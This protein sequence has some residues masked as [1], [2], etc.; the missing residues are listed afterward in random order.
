MAL[1]F[2][3]RCEATTLTADDYSA[4]DMGASTT[5]TPALNA[6]AKREGTNGLYT[7][8]ATS[9]YYFNPTDLMASGV[10]TVGAAAF[11]IYLVT[12]LP[13]NFQTIGLYAWNSA[14]S[15]D[16]FRTEH[17][18]SGN[19]KFVMGRAGGTTTTITT[20]GGAITVGA[21]FGV[22]ARWDAP[23]D[24][25]AL[26]IYDASGALVDSITS[27]AAG[28]SDSYPT[29][30]T[31]IRWGNFSAR[32]DAVYMD[33]IFL[34]DSYSEPLEDFLDITAY[35]EYGVI[36][37]APGGAYVFPTFYQR[38]NPLLRM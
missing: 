18:G 2:F 32:T 10:S 21:W 29:T 13:S 11:S 3:W 30:L 37:P 25:M 38:P 34:A 22:V 15:G 33:N 6:T 28:I 35:S 16:N 9:F 20:T 12:S 23:N 19:L 1:T 14:A 24:M 31:S 4:N 27:T 7:N 5:G 17:A 26:E 8:A 36:P